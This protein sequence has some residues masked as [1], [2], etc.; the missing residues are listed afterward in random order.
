MT[1]VIDRQAQVLLKKAAEDEAV[2]LRPGAPDAPFGFHVQQALEKLLKALLSQLSIQYR[3]SHNLSS[4][5]N[6]V[7]KSGEGLPNTVIAFSQLETFAVFN[8]YDEIPEFHVLDRSRCHRN[9]P[10]P[11]RAYRGPYRRALRDAL[12]PSATIEPSACRA[13]ELNPRCAG[14]VK[15]LC[16]QTICRKL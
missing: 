15:V 5:V 3:L 7:Q 16:S 11:P 12:A 2:T 14:R 4:L 13:A 8:R 10:H 1:V 9:R 6:L